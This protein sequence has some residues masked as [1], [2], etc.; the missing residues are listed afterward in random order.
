MLRGHMWDS[1]PSVS[2]QRRSATVTLH[3]PYL[4][5]HLGIRTRSTHMGDAPSSVI[6]NVDFM[7]GALFIK[8][9]TEVL[10]SFVVL[11]RCSM[12]SGQYPQAIHVITD[13]AI[14][15]RRQRNLKARCGLGLN[16]KQSKP[17]FTCSWPDSNRHGISPI[18]PS[19]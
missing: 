17:L 6:L 10:G 19:N 2:V 7:S 15:H 16:P 11:P 12:I 5:N 8:L 3:G 1:N 9:T 14:F 13:L 18:S 4:L